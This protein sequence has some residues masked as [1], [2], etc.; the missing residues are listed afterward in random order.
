MKSLKTTSLA[1]A[2]LFFSLNSQADNNPSNNNSATQMKTGNRNATTGAEAAFYNPAGTVFGADGFTVEFSV[3]PF[4]SSQS[5]YDAAFDK[6]YESKTSSLFYPALNLRYKKDKFSVFSNIGITNGGGSGNYDDGLPMFEVLGIS[7]MLGAIMGGTPGLPS[8]NPFDYQYSSNFEGSAYGIGGSIGAAYKFTDWL[9]ASAAIQFSSQK[10]SE[11]GTLYIDYAAVNANIMQTDIDISHTGNN[12]GLIFGLN[13]KPNDKL[14]IA[15]TFRYYTELELET[16]INDGK[17]GGGLYVDGTKSLNTYVPYYSFGANYQIN[18]KLALEADFNLS[19]YSMLSLD[20]DANDLNTAEYYNN[21]IDIGLAMEYQV[22]D[23]VNWG[24]GF[25]YAPSKMKEEYM[26]ELEFEL[27]TFWLNT[28]VT[29]SPI[30]K[31]EI[32]LAFQAGL[33]TEE[34]DKEFD[35]LLVPGTTYTQTYK[36][37]VSYAIGLGVAYSF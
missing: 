21:G 20:K 6:T 14:L 28:G 16:K 13:L 19:L 27:N 10:N 1:I 34:I 36:K 4:W 12:M 23:I 3:L 7:Q 8:N 25:T 31:L 26:N 30:D 15:Q 33:P 11:K 35:S 2:M 29:I 22:M 18:D 5:V 17:D 32:N 24:L 37:E 9:S